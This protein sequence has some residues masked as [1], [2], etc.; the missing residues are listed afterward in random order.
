MAACATLT[1]R[2]AQQ[3]HAGRAAHG[4]GGGP[5]GQHQAAAAAAA[6]AARHW[7]MPAAK[8]GRQAGA[9]LHVE[10]VLYEGQGARVGRGAEVWWWGQDPLLDKAYKCGH[11]ESSCSHSK[12]AEWSS[13]GARRHGNTACNASVG[14][15]PTDGL[16]PAPVPFIIP[17]APPPASPPTPPPS[18]DAP[19]TPAAAP[20]ASAAAMASLTD[21]APWMSAAPRPP[22]IMWP[23]MMS[24]SS[25]EKGQAY[26]ISCSW[27][28]DV[29]W[30]WNN[31]G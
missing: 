30:F 20:A 9:H 12:D 17:P 11:T 6:G 18:G 2:H 14:R 16:V 31:K 21:M 13:D 15:K 26:G 7:A 1:W 23:A 27:G 22:C 4:P 5:L 19:P 8:V 24:G 29:S 10:Q 3:H 28:F 25:A